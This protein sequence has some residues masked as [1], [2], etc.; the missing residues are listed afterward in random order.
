MTRGARVRRA[1]AMA[2][3]RAFNPLARRLAGVAPWWV[4]LETTG[5]RS[6]RARQVPLARGPMDGSTAWLIAVHGSHSSFAKNIAAHP[7]VRLKV[8][9]QWHAGRATLAPLDAAVLSR[10]SRYARMGPRAAGIDPTL[11]RIDLEEPA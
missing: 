6:G 7:A 2:F 5:R 4:V 8:A 9:G 3:W 11:V 1:L 10:F